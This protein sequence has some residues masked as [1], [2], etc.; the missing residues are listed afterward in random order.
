MI[1]RFSPATLDTGI[2]PSTVMRRDVAGEWVRYADHL[3]LEARVAVLEGEVEMLREE[4]N[5]D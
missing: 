2:G 3:A 1:P 4:F 5:G